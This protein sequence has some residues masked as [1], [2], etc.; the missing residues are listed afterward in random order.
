MAPEEAAAAPAAATSCMVNTLSPHIRRSAH[1]TS[2]HP[3]LLFLFC[4]WGWGFYFYFRC[5]I[6]IIHTAHHF[7]HFVFVFDIYNSYRIISIFGQYLTPVY[8]RGETTAQQCNARGVARGDALMEAK[9]KAKRKSI[10]SIAPRRRHHRLRL[11]LPNFCCRCC[12]CC[13][14]PLRRSLHTCAR[15]AP[16]LLSVGAFPDC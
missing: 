7:R 15:V 14:R 1:I 10:K 5:F 12:C 6:I 4:G 16:Q 3:L 9:A 8:S 13:C 11:L 2:R